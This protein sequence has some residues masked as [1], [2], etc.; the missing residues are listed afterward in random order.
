MSGERIFHMVGFAR[1]TKNRPVVFRVGDAEFRFGP[2]ETKYFERGEA[3][4]LMAVGGRF[5]IAVTMTDLPVEK[6]GDGGGNGKSEHD[7]LDVVAYDGPGV[8]IDT[9]G[10]ASL[11]EDAAPVGDDESWNGTTAPDSPKALIVEKG[12]HDDVVVTGDDDAGGDDEKKN[13]ETTKRRRRRK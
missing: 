5:G 1:N 13:V 8:L 7:L 9:M 12:E 3:L 10:S 4:V 11:V 2:Y 6:A